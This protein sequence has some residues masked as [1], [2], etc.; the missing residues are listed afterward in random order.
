MDD[1][2]PRERRGERT[3]QSI[4]EAA[5]A[6]VIEKG[7]NKLSLR[8]IARRA[9][10]SPAGLYEYFASKDAI[11]D[12]LICDASDRF[13]THLSRVSTALPV[14]EY[15]VELGMTY[16][17]FAH[18]NPDHFMMMFTHYQAL[19]VVNLSDFAPSGGSNAYGLLMDAVQRALDSGLFQA[20]PGYDKVG[21]T[22]S[23]WSLV[24]GLA[25]LQATYLRQFTWDFATAD[26]QAIRTFIEGLRR[27]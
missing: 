24:H 22:Y 8:E 19:P 5:L 20:Q 9:D 27:G 6:L 11:I 14:D 23:F 15:L 17:E 4:L 16:I 13:F 10:Y 21:M 1:T 18:L 3:R 26:R 2:T 7:L 25:I 12:A